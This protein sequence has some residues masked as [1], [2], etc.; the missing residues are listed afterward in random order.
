MTIKMFLKDRINFALTL[1][2]FC[3]NMDFVSCNWRSW[4]KHQIILNYAF[5]SLI[6]VVFLINIYPINVKIKQNILH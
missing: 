4:H 2:A 1:F 5:I 3:T 6:A